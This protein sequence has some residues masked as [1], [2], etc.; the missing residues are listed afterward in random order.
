MSATTPNPPSSATTDHAT[1]AAPTSS[2]EPLDA[3]FR[4]HVGSVF[5]ANLADGILLAAI[6][7]I[8][9]TLTRSPAAISMLQVAFWLP[10]LLLGLAA[11]VVV[12]RVDRNRLRMLWMGIRVVLVAG[13]TIAALTD[14]LSIGLLI[15]VVGGYGLTQVF[16]DLAGATMVPALAPRA[17]WSAANGRVMAAEQLGNTFI[18]AP[19]GG[20]LVVLG[21]GWA[22]GLPVALGILFIVICFVGIRGDFRP[23]RDAATRPVQELREGLT[24]L[25]KH[26]VLRA[27]LVSGG[28]MN[29]ANAG[30]FAV[31][32]LWVVGPE[33][34]VGLAAAHYPL[35][36]A[37]LAVGALVGAVTAERLT[38]RFAEVPVM[39]T[40][41]GLNTA[42]LLVP[43]LVPHPAAIAAAFFLVGY[44]N[45]VGN[46]VGQTVRQR[47]VPSRL[48]GRT[49]GASRTLGYGLMPLGALLGGLVGEVWG[50][51][52]VFI[53]AVVVA[54]LGLAY[55]LLT[56]R[57]RMV[58]E[59]EVQ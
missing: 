19:L 25:I 28:V 26:P 3:R 31:F 5:V 40:V 32:V 39:L 48:L 53:G 34:T 47:L 27:V 35:L 15:A 21:A 55:P 1:I 46:V 22:F 57:Q 10:W 58:D 33:S 12:D 8:A 14:R 43:V 2:G 51:Q 9:I 45:M 42:L 17:R 54:F 38:R 56:V 24:F 20:F 29:M 52:P 44:T 30:Y 13:L 23:E 37:T 7:L 16:I 59:L 49:G 4:T 36:L 11:G 50:L 6:P 18:G 41:W